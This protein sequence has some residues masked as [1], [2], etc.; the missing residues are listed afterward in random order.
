[1]ALR[2]DRADR[3]GAGREGRTRLKEE[4]GRESGKSAWGRKVINKN[5]RKK[6]DIKAHYLRVGVGRHH[7]STIFDLVVC[8]ESQEAPIDYDVIISLHDRQPVTATR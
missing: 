8:V 5:L 6:L 4:G 2:K 1:V 7:S 3:Q